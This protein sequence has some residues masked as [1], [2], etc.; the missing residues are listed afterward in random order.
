MSEKKVRTGKITKQQK[1]KLLELMRA[2]TRVASGQ[3]VGVSGA[4]NS[5]QVW[6]TVRGELNACGGACKTAEQ[7]KKCWS[8]WKVAVKKQQSAYNRFKNLTAFGTKV[9]RIPSFI[10]GLISPRSSSADSLFNLNNSMKRA[11]GK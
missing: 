11:S 1:S 10:Y 9:I 8:D 3:F 6:D 5:Q 2:N 4:K 7:W